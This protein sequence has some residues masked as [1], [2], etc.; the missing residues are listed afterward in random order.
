MKPGRLGLLELL[1]PRRTL[2]ELAAVMI[3]AALVNLCLPWP[4]KL[5]FDGKSER[6]AATPLVIAGIF[7]G[8]SLVRGLLFAFRRILVTRL[9]E[10]FG[11]LL[12]HVLLARILW[13]PIPALS[14]WTKADLL[15]RVV[16]DVE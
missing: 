12:S 3:L 15:L 16:D 4:F 10:N 13:V 5:I 8:L 9:C 6:W 11:R 1:R 7:I 14:H 2:L